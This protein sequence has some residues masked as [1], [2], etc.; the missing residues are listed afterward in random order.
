MVPDFWKPLTADY[1]A[2][3]AFFVFQKNGP[4]NSE[5]PE[6]LT[7]LPQALFFSQKNGPPHMFGSGSWYQHQVAC[8]VPNVA[9]HAVSIPFVSKSSV[10]CRVINLRVGVSVPCCGH[11]VDMFCGRKHIDAKNMCGSPTG[12]IL[13]MTVL[14]FLAGGLHY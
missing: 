7:T 8:R 11:P 1:V 9:C 13:S 4:H 10:S 3:G 2:A 12:V 5:S 6:R 14:T